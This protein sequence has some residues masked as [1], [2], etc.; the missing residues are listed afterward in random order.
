MS[1]TQFF[2]ILVENPVDPVDPN[3][4]RHKSTTISTDAPK[5]FFYDNK[6]T[7]TQ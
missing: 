2:M 6:N 4:D 7:R 1:K 3:C 5:R